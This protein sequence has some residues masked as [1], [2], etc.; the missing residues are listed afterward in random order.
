MTD[1]VGA[2]KETETAGLTAA[3]FTLVEGRTPCVPGTSGDI[4]AEVSQGPFLR[5]VRVISD[6]QIRPR[7]TR[8]RHEIAGGSH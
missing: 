8:T 1:E 7:R 4:E 2:L 6:W 3:T 5:D